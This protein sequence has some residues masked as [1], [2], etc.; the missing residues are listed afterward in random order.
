MPETHA[1][2]TYAALAQQAV[3]TS[4]A[5]L[6]PNDAVH[7]GLL[8]WC[9]QHP[10]I[11]VL[12]SGTILTSTPD[13]PLL[14]SCKT[15]M[16]AQQVM[17]QRVLPAD[18]SLLQQLL[19]QGTA[20]AHSPQVSLPSEGSSQQQRLRLLVS[21]ALRLAASDIH[22]EVRDPFTYVRLRRHGELMLLAQWPAKLAREIIAVAFNQETDHTHT[23]F[24]PLVPQNAAMPLT[25]DGQDLRLRLASLPA[26]Q[27][28]DVVMRLLRDTPQIPLQLEQLGYAPR[29]L[30]L[31]KKALQMPTG[32]IIIAGPTGSGKTTTLASCLQFLGKTRKIYAIEDP[33]EHTLEHAT[34]IPVNTLHDDRG[35][36]SMARTALRM[37]PDIIALGEMRDEQTAQVLVRAAITGHLVLSSLHTHT[38]VEIPTRLVELGISRSL[39]GNPELLVCLV[40]QRLVATLCQRCAQPVTHLAAHA[41]HL[42]RWRK[43]LGPLSSLRGRG[44]GCSDCHQQ[45]IQGRRVVAEVIWLDHASRQYIQQ[46]ESL[47]WRHYL[48]QQGWRSY[49]E[50]LLRLCQQGQVDPFDL[51]KLIGCLNSTADTHF[52]Y[53]EF[54]REQTD[55]H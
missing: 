25:V 43:T 28:F 13:S 26:H 40:A 38:A 15:L 24:N 6:D 7:P 19:D 29:E 5:D 9:L 50:Q 53:A 39:L 35:F 54:D 16:L 52:N 48:K 22:L 4:Q 1:L 14:P 17:P 32:A 21:E 42:T 31:L 47:A 12:T 10:H 55:A 3:L 45:G 36:A 46:G 30:A 2:Q 27:G 49:H 23:H 37:D 8:T 33:I 51:E 44:S 20:L 34:Q 18:A 41:N 11:V